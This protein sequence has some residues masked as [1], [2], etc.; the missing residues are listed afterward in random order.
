MSNTFNRETESANK[1]AETFAE[2]RRLEK[3]REFAEK[4]MQSEDP[5]NKI[6]TT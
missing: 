1:L 6:N 2:E 4:K 3:E 5:R